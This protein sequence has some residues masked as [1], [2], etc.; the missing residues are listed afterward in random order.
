MRGVRQGVLQMT[1]RALRGNDIEADA[2]ARSDS[3]SARTLSCTLLAS[4]KTSTSPV[5]SSS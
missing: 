1:A 5:M 3:G 2:G 4:S